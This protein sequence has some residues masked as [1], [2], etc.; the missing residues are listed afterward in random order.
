MDA[1]QVGIYLLLLCEQ[2]DH[3]PIPNDPEEIADITRTKPGYSQAMATLE[4]CFSLTDYGWINERLELIRGEQTA[5][6]ERLSLAGK[7]GAAKRYGT[8]HKKPG[9]G[10]P[11]ARPDDSQAI[12]RLK[13]PYSIR[14]E[15]RR[16]EEKKEEAAP[17]RAAPAG[18]WTGV[19]LPRPA[20]DALGRMKH[21][22]GEVATSATLRTRFLMDD[23]LGMPDPSVVGLD[24]KAKAAVVGAA[25]VEMASGGVDT[26]K[27]RALAAFVTRLRSAP[28][29]NGDHPQQSAA[30][31]QADL[32]QK[33]ERAR[34]RSARAST[35]AEVEFAE[36]HRTELVEAKSWLDDHAEAKDRVEAR[37]RRATSSGGS[38]G[39]TE[40]FVEAA[41]VQAVRAERALEQSG[42]A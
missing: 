21:Q 35:K 34:V 33:R 22:G 3:G 15:E 32:E 16:E 14:E 11:I 30:E 25:L 10:H 4:R 18:S 36:R 7:E 29:P 39:K 42:A 9:H 38:L 37:V 41:L 23:A 8:K 28:A 5:K 6:S 20:L 17:A 2:W 26:F 27:P 24:V 13:P 12:A 1:E 40:A 31:E 19:D